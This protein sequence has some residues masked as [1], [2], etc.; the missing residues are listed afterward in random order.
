MAAI[1]D[2]KGRLFQIEAKVLR[3]GSEFELTWFQLSLVLNRE[4]S[5]SSTVEFFRE[6]IKV[7]ASG[8]RD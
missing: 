7:A 3:R 4:I 2:L 5:N 6:P 8:K 1:F